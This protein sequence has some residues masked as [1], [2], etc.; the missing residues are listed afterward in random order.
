VVAP[1][2]A[3]PVRVGVVVVAALVRSV[4]I[5]T[6]GP[7]TMGSDTALVLSVGLLSFQ[8]MKSASSVK[9]LDEVATQTRTLP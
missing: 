2:V 6:N 4:V 1:G 9:P 5:A 7:I 3:L 8:H